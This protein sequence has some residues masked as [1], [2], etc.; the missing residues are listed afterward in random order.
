M[1]VE[2]DSSVVL[3]PLTNTDSTSIGYFDSKY[4]TVNGIFNYEE[5]GHM[6]SNIGAIENI[7]RMFEKIQWYDGKKE[8]Y[9]INKKGLQKSK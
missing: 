6:G 4:V 2:F 5:S 1:W 3:K 9:E 7:D 8:L